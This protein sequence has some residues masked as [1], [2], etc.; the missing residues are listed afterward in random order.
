MS[1]VIRP[2][3]NIDAQVAAI[4]T[5]VCN[6]VLERLN[7]SAPTPVFSQGG[8]Y[9]ISD[10]NQNDTYNN[11]PFR[12]VLTAVNYD[13][14]PSGFWSW[15]Q[16]LPNVVAGG[17]EGAGHG[18][19]AVWEDYIGG[20]S[21]TSGSSPSTNPSNAAYEANNQ[22]ATVGDIVNMRRAYFD[23]GYGTWLYVFDS[24]DWTPL[25]SGPLT[26]ED[27]PGGTPVT[28]V[29]AI[30]FDNVQ[31][32]LVTGTTPTAEVTIQDAGTTQSGVVNITTQ[33]WTGDKGTYGSF[34]TR[35]TDGTNTPGFIMEGDDG[36]ESSFT[37]LA[38]AWSISVA[39]GDDSSSNSISGSSS[40][41]TYPGVTFISS[42]DSAGDFQDAKYGVYDNTGS[43]QVGQYGTGASG[44]TFAGGLFLSAGSGPT[45]ANGGTGAD[46]SGTGPGVVYQATTGGALAVGTSAGAYTPTNVSSD[47]SFD[48]NSTTLDEIAD[49]LGTL[50]ADLQGLKILQ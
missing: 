9:F 47:R 14:N 31:G 34:I 38:T 32:F 13:Y 29:T 35:G 24:V 6:A 10:T 37:A 36:F 39:S 30:Q 17:N 5:E 4:L 16:Q 8:G 42:M 26:V 20:L 21:G 12:A 49:V 50:I 1:V 43:P 15:T 11:K 40:D 7:V 25:V 22:A 19:G 48:A 18:H 28:P 44:D 41:L 3:G 46:L 23:D 33:D 27:V 45:L 2:S